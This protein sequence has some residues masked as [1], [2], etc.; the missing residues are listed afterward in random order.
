MRSFT[1][2]ELILLVV[3]TM[4]LPVSMTSS[5]SA[6]FP[7]FELASHTMFL[8]VIAAVKTAV[9]VINSSN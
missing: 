5:V 3:L 2:V 7:T 8:Q 4:Y 9:V 1:S 6:I